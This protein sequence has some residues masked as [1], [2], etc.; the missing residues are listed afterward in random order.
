LNLC[1]IVNG[2]RGGA[3]LVGKKEAGHLVCRPSVRSPTVLESRE[4]HASG[5][6][7]RQVERAAEIGVERARA[8]RRRA[9]RRLKRPTKD[10]DIARAEAALKRA[11]L[12]LDIAEKS[13]RI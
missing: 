1:S 9:K 2:R 13:G 6:S 10:T 12:R 8:A 3:Q 5:A 11:L 4:S 7:I